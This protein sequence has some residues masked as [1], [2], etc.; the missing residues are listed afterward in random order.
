MTLLAKGVSEQSFSEQ[1]VEWFSENGWVSDGWL[2][3]KLKSTDNSLPLSFALPNQTQNNHWVD[4]ALDSYVYRFFNENCL[5][6]VAQ[7]E[8]NFDRT[9]KSLPQVLGKV[10]RLVQRFSSTIF[11][12]NGQLVTFYGKQAGFRAVMPSTRLWNQMMAKPFFVRELRLD[13]VPES[14]DTSGEKLWKC[15]LTTYLLSSLNMPHTI[16]FFYAFL[17]RLLHQPHHYDRWSEVLSIVCEQGDSVLIQVIKLLFDPLDVAITTPSD[18]PP[19]ENERIKQ[20]I[21]C[22]VGPQLRARGKANTISIN[23]PKSGKSHFILFG[24]ILRNVKLSGKTITVRDCFSSA[25]NSAYL[26]LRN[27]LP[28][29]INLANWV[30]STTLSLAGSSGNTFSPDHNL[31][32]LKSWIDFWA[33]PCPVCKSR[34]LCIHVFNRL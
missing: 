7:L 28:L 10:D 25:G 27:D 24:D 18:P 8:L 4:H 30:Y 5:D 9:L 11:S 12:F 19:L 2:V 14:L 31:H 17:G 16:L 6:P 3:W 20:A 32:N 1:I 15:P 23:F 33:I 26:T 34:K 22:Y 29:I 21:F 13:W